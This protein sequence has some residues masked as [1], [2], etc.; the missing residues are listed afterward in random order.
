MAKDVLTLARAQEIVQAI[1]AAC[2][3]R[4]GVHDSNLN[5]FKVLEGLSLAD[6]LRAV[7]A[8]KAENERRQAAAKNDAASPGVR[9]FMTPDD[10]LTAAVYT[11]LNYNPDPDPLIHEP[12]PAEGSGEVKGLVVTTFRYSNEEE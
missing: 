2:F 9:L 3:I 8:L 5:A 6:M 7:E 1:N 11:M 10:R 12:I 4:A